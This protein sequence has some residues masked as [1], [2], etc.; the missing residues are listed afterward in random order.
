MSD[1]QN[2]L[3]T[4]TRKLVNEYQITDLEEHVKETYLWVGIIFACMLSIVA[5]CQDRFTWGEIICTL[6]IIQVM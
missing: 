4:K 2:E 3:S 1:K 6:Q 5:I